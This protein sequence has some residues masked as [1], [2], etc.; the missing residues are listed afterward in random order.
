M[1]LQ[2]TVSTG[3]LHPGANAKGIIFGPSTTQGELLYTV[4][5]GRTCY[6]TSS[7]YAKVNGVVY[8]PLQAHHANGTQY[9]SVPYYLTEGMTLTVGSSSEARGV[10]IEFDA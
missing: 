1:G 7:V 9:G 4:P 8:P 10:G 3:S 2:S 5:S 6:I